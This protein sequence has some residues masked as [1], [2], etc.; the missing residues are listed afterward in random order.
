MRD[1]FVRVLIA[2]DSEDDRVLITRALGQFPAFQ[3]AGVTAD[4]LETV[5][6]LTGAP[7]FDNREKFPFPDLLLLDYQMPACSGVAVLERLHKGS[8]PREII[9]W[10]DNPYLIDQK[11]AIHL[12]ACLICTKPHASFG[13]QEILAQLYPDSFA[14]RRLM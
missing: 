12:G 4:G 13:L 7:P 5:A 14:V 3:L 11:K 8:V 9:L 6:W 2:D 1:R 10:S